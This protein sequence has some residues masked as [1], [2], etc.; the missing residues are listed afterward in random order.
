MNTES[1]TSWGRHSPAAAAAEVTWSTDMSTVEP[2]FS[3]PFHLSRLLVSRTANYDNL[4]HTLRPDPQRGRHRFRIHVRPL[5][6]TFSTTHNKSFFRSI[7]SS[8]PWRR[9]N[10]GG[11]GVE[12]TIKSE[13][14]TASF[15]VAT[16]SK[17]IWY[18]SLASPIA[19]TL[20]T[21]E[22]WW[23]IPLSLGMYYSFVERPRQGQEWSLFGLHDN[24]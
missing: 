11:G 24:S 10:S 9:Q 20:G 2:L 22:C 13:P 3:T 5:K 23:K 16:F 19:R 17:S 21:W 14:N 1:S 4:T 8:A 7:S 12:Q 15:F 18:C 6:S